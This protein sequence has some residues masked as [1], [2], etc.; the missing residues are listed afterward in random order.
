MGINTTE[1]LRRQRDI[2][3]FMD[4][5]G[6][7]APACFF[8]D[9]LAGSSAPMID[10]M[11]CEAA[12]C[13]AKCMVKDSERHKLECAYAARTR[14]EKTPEVVAWLA[15]RKKR[16]VT[17]QRMRREF[18]EEKKKQES[19]TAA[20]AAAP[21]KETK[22]EE[23]PKPTPAEAVVETPEP[24]PAP[25]GTL[26]P[27]PPPHTAPTPVPE[28][29]TEEKTAESAST[30]AEEEPGL[31]E[32]SKGDSEVL[33]DEEN[34]HAVLVAN[35][36]EID[37]YVAT[38]GLVV[39]R[40]YVRT[41]AD[42]KKRVFCTCAREM[43]VDEEGGKKVKYYGGDHAHMRF[44][45]DPSIRPL[46]KKKAAPPPESKSE[47]KPT[48]PTVAP[49]SKKTIDQEIAEAIERLKVGGAP[50][51]EGMVRR[52]E[53]PGFKPENPILVADGDEVVN[54]L[55]DAGLKGVSQSV[56]K[57]K[58]E[59]ALSVKCA[60][61]KYNADGSFTQTHPSMSVFY[62]KVKKPTGVKIT[63]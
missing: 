34:E 41:P 16:W 60:R 7:L 31:V 27:P 19:K 38:L 33:E 17:Y 1:L 53:V 48:A 3:A 30:L 40:R 11:C 39:R 29:K 2:D 9:K 28:K 52:G 5:R 54:W 45:I 44:I 15:E 43:I 10:C 18:C 62:F 23:K 14:R 20:V 55:K 59:N 6:V 58:G 24:V 35:M 37:E 49:D 32:E 56:Y 13:N 25:Q 47:E 4:E 26:P 22:E 50:D 36:D 42:G 61:G 12:Y 57:N 8:C 46:E 21:K 51:V 63:L